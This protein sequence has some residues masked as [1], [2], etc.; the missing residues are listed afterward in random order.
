MGEIFINKQ[1]KDFYLKIAFSVVLAGILIVS[2]YN[3]T[4]KLFFKDSWQ[5]K[6]IL[7]Q[8]NSKI[9]DRD[10]HFTYDKDEDIYVFE[11]SDS[12]ASNVKNEQLYRHGEIRYTTGEDE[13][14]EGYTSS[15]LTRVAKLGLDAHEET[16]KE[17]TIKVVSPLKK[18]EYMLMSVNG[19]EVYRRF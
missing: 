8:F 9:E 14:S 4:N 16:K 3:V 12:F 10:G 18:S 1:K 11:F 19:S 5:A 15:F 13:L 6:N 2:V 7:K 17:I